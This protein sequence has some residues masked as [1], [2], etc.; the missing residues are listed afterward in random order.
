MHGEIAVVVERIG[1]ATLLRSRVKDKAASGLTI[2]KAQQKY[3]WYFVQD[4]SLGLVFTEPS[5]VHG[6]ERDDNYNADI[7]LLALE[8]ISAYEIRAVLFDVWKNR[9]GT[10]SA[11]YVRMRMQGEE[12]SQD[13]SWWP[14]RSDLFTSVMYVARV[15]Y[16]DGSIVEADLDPLTR[17]IQHIDTGISRQDLLP[18]EPDP[19]DRSSLGQT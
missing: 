2:Q 6:G 15:K 18:D 16:M 13:P 1:S 4:T 19:V 14:A 7:D 9:T 10:V 8:D 5:G 17:A 11:T 3:E 12:F